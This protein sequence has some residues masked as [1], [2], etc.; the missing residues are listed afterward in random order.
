M[1]MCLGSLEKSFAFQLIDAVG[2]VRQ[3]VG[4]DDDMFPP[5]PDMNQLHIS[6]GFHIK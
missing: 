1:L 2:G 4:H 6:G 3:A 5:I